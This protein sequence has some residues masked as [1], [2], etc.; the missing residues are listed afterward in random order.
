[1]MM[2]MMMLILHETTNAFQNAV[3]GCL[4]KLPKLE[5]HPP[6]TFCRL[7]PTTCGPSSAGDHN[8]G[9]DGHDC[10]APPND[11]RL[12]SA[13]PGKRREAWR[14]SKRLPDHDASAASSCSDGSEYQ[15]VPAQWD[16]FVL[17]RWIRHLAAT[18]QRVQCF[19]A[20]ST[21]TPTGRHH[22]NSRKG[23]R[24][25]VPLPLLCPDSRRH[26]RRRHSRT[27]D[28]QPHCWPCCCYC[29]R[30]LLRCYRPCNQ[31]HPLLLQGWAPC[32]WRLAEKATVV[33]EEQNQDYS[34]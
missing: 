8:E 20:P 3:R 27:G 26:C 12:D 34:P 15:L 33:A 18:P 24:E 1:M 17:A 11:Q 2:M 28:L 19:C 14:G 16:G 6:N 21:D 25:V 30:S 29:G 9:W 4:Q 22:H 32:A 13:R 10:I 5:R 7:R 23:E 31:N